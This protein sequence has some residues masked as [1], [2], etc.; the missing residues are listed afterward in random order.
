MTEPLI[1]IVI[2]VYNAEKYLRACLDSVLAQTYK[3]WEAICVNDGSSDNS[4]KILEE[5]AAKDARFHIINQP[6]SGVSTARNTGLQQTT[7]KYLMYLDSD[8]IWHPQTLEILQN[9]MEKSNADMGCFKYQE[10]YPD[11]KIIYNNY[12]VDSDFKLCK[13]PLL[14][15]IHRKI[16]TGILIW[17][18]IYR[19]DKIKNI[20]FCNL[21]QGEDDVYSLSVLLK[22]SS[23]AML[24]NV[25]YYYMQNP[26]SIMHQADEAK[27]RGN[28]LKIE[29]KITAIIQDYCL[30]S[31]DELLKKECQKYLSE[32]ILF[33]EHLLYALRKNKSKIS[34]EL[35]Y[36]SELK[37]L[38]V[39]QPNLMRL[40][41]KIIWWLANHR[42][43][44]L[45]ELVAKL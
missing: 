9:V 27:I 20:S 17:N 29:E 23:I 40:R 24:D 45:A 6:N 11:T 34:Q 3:N 5:Y 36:L 13:T 28:R 25:L 2:P 41:F 39:F 4:A 10:V 7:G 31:S 21:K 37:T 8:D 16:K 26:Q 14:S 43:L 38:N 1:S 42:L 12:M 19:T 32:K 33:R 22:I 44:S 35:D 15:F 30:R 18:K